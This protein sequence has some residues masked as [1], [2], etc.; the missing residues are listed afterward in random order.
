MQTEAMLRSLSNN[1]IGKRYNDAYALLEKPVPELARMNK[2]DRNQFIWCW[3]QREAL[4]RWWPT[5]AQNQRDRW[6]HPDAVKRRYLD[7]LGEGGV[8][9]LVRPSRAVQTQE[10]PAATTPLLSLKR[11]LESTTAKKLPKDP[12]EDLKRSSAR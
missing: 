10:L 8:P 5:N 2:T 1:P 9:L 4:E 3:Q 11:C 12:A 7:D 6:S